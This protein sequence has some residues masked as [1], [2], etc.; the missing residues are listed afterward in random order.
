MDFNGVI[1][2]Y[3]FEN[4]KCYVGQTNNLVRR[5]NYYR[6]HYKTNPYPFLRALNKYGFDETKF[7]I[8]ATANTRSDLNILEIELIKSY[9]STNK[10]KGYNL[11]TG[12]GGLSGLKHTKK[13]KDKMSKM[14]MGESNPFFGKSHTKE[15]LVKMSEA[16]KKLPPV[17]LGKSH[18]DDYK[19]NM[20]KNHSQSRKIVC[21]E[22]NE[23]FHSIRECAKQMKLNAG[24]I[25]KVLSGEY[26]HHHNFT[27][28]YID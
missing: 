22:T 25:G 11:S 21:C 5:I 16:A 13:Y 15:S 7:E 1:Y 8:I 17:W 23:E 12:G 9:D 28:K 20:S 14:Y 10:E 24:S 26:S 4:G 19:I 3:V 27:F 2:K 6:N 18:T